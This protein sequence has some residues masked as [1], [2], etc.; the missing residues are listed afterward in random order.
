M[1]NQTRAIIFTVLFFGIVFLGSISLAALFNYFNPTANQF[2]TLLGTG[3]VLFLVKLVYDMRLSQL[4]Y[5]DQ[6]Q[7]MVDKFPK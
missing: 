6:I 4:E 5:N 7:K 3:V 2:I 1:K